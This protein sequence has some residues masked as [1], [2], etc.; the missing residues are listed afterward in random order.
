MDVLSLPGL[1]TPLLSGLEFSPVGTHIVR[2]DP[3]RELMNFFFSFNA[4]KF[5]VLTRIANQLI[6]R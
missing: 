6:H 5:C 3:R 2:R 1:P 4:T